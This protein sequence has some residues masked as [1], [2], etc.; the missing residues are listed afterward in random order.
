MPMLGRDLALTRLSVKR[1]SRQKL[2]LPHECERWDPTSESSLTTRRRARPLLAGLIGAA[3][4]AAVWRGLQNNDWMGP[5]VVGMF[6]GGIGFG[7]WFGVVTGYVRTNHSVFSRVDR[8]V[9]FWFI[10]ALLMSV[11]LGCFAILVFGDL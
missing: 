7:L 4:C 3:I 11:Y 9:A 10:I 1:N 6:T 5:L 2:L 8:P